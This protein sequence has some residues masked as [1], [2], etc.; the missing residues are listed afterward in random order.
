MGMYVDLSACRW[1]LIKIVD[2]K[3]C[4]KKVVLL[5]LKRVKD[6]SAAEV[7]ANRRLVMR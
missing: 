4:R 3:N 1:R 6:L 7:R 2:K 5:T